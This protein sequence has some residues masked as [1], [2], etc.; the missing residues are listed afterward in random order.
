MI[1]CTSADMSYS[2]P[3]TISSA[4]EWTNIDYACWKDTLRQCLRD[5]KSVGDIATF[6]RYTAY[7]NPGLKIEGHTA[8]PL[9][10]TPDHAELIKGAC[11][12][13]PFGK[14]DDTLVDT[15]VRNTWELEHHQFELLNPEWS[16][17][18]VRVG[19]ESA[20]GLGLMKIGLKPH[21][22]LL[23]EKGSFFKRHKDTEKERGM[24][25]TLVVCLPSEHAGGDVH[26]RFG[27]KERSYSTG[28]T[29]RFDLTALA[30]YSDVSHEVKELEAGYRLALTYNIVQNDSKKQSAGFLGQQAQQIKKF[31][32]EW[33]A[34]FP[35]KEKLIHPLDHK[36]SEASLSM[37]N[38]KGRDE[39]VCRALHEVASS[40]GV[41]LLFA[42]LTRSEG[43]DVDDD[44]EDTY[45]DLTALYSPDG[46][47]IGRGDM[48]QDEEILDLKKL[49]EG[50]PDSEDEGEFTGNEAAE[51]TLRYHN[52]VVVLVKKNSILDY[53]N[54]VTRYN[55]SGDLHTQNLVQM[56]V[57]DM[58]TFLEDQT[59][60]EIAR[61]PLLDVI[62][63]ALGP[64][65]SSKALTPVA[66]YWALDLQDSALC[67]SVM[68]AAAKSGVQDIRNS[69]IKTAG[70]FIEQRFDDRPESIDWDKWVGSAADL[71]TVAGVQD[72]INSFIPVFEKDAVR[73]SFIK[74]GESKLSEK[75]DNQAVFDVS[76]HLFFVKTIGEKHDNKDWLMSSL[77]P[78]LASRGTR[79]LIY[80]VLHSV[81][82]KKDQV[83][84]AIAK[85]FFEY[86]LHHSFANLLL[87]G[88][89]M[90]TKPAGSSLPNLQP[91]TRGPPTHVSPPCSV[92][93]QDFVAV[94]DHCLTLGLTEKGRELLEA[95]CN[96]LVWT[97][98]E[99]HPTKVSGDVVSQLLSPIVDTLKKHSVPPTQGVKDLFD[100]I[101]R[102]G[103]HVNVPRNPPKRRGWAYKPRVCSRNYGGSKC[104]DCEA[105]NAFLVARDQKSWRYQVGKQTRDHLEDQ[106]HCYGDGGYPYGSG[107]HYFKI[108][109][110]RTQRT[111]ALVVEKTG[112]GF[113]DAVVSWQQSVRALESRLAPLR[114]E[115]VAEMLGDE[116]Y[117]ELV[118]AEDLRA[119]LAASESLLPSGMKRALGEA[120][121]AE[122]PGAKKVRL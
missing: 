104:K 66:V 33:R 95:C 29:S 94:V 47:P 56:V 48:P 40:C 72:I 105:L 76:E 28:P 79:G 42:H 23:Y 74:W 25:G 89:D 7:T 73:D 27:S 31:L 93:L 112:R 11:R 101:L 90:V 121:T 68:A 15:S 75:F 30:W 61:P 106:L 77:I 91:P 54:P 13:A 17:F 14:G 88:A 36:Y 16:A 110:D 10:L 50:N 97:K 70:S 41:Y 8:F 67:K 85:E 37:R 71:D 38:M 102:E 92:P 111:H 107:T 60:N 83:E 12:Q 120:A 116:A 44:D 32:V 87:Q 35:N 52:T 108:T 51:S 99:W 115:M 43:G 98:E 80:G 9:P 119:Q 118:A 81:F 55:P 122:L 18:L 24:V 34:M 2:S 84:F 5:I 39:A 78:A 82:V 117:R 62:R 26:V 20:R 45:N 58:V 109:T 100:V 3:E 22:L 96:Q 114:T 113:A 64:G 21:K 53:V 19:A 57:D 4:D 1:Q 6:T 65:G 63:K 86:V 103:L 59:T 49:S 69:A 46:K